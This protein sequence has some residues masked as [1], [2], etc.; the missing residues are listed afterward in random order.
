LLFPDSYIQS[1]SERMLLYRELDS[2]ETEAALQLFEASLN[3]RFGKLPKQSR[4][5]IEVVRLRWLAID[6]GIERII[7]KNEKMICYFIA[8]QKS[9]YYQSEAFTK[10]LNYVQKNPGKCR[11]KEQKDKLTLSFEKIKSIAGAKAILAEV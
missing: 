7:L 10:V 11:M 5:L 2:M 8:D 9:H 3:D 4:E 1:V 6:L